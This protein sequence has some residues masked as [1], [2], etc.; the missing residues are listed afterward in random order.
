MSYQPTLLCHSPTRGWSLS[1]HLPQ[2]E[3]VVVLSY[4]R[5]CLGAEMSV[6]W[7]DRFCRLVG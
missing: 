2:A 5:I 1:P 3:G 7:V 6:L 4:H